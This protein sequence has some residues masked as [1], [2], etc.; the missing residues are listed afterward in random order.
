MKQNQDTGEGVKAHLPSKLF[1]DLF[2]NPECLCA[3]ACADSSTPTVRA[4]F[5]SLAE[6]TS[7]IPNAPQNPGTLHNSCRPC[8]WCTLFPKP[9]GESFYSC[10]RWSFL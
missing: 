1:C 10:S 4:T 5:P 8:L 6:Q 3:G 9:G 7:C 2:Q